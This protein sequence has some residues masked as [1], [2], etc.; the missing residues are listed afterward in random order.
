MRKDQLMTK[1]YRKK[2]IEIMVEA[3]RARAIID[4]I[5]KAGAKGYTIVPE[6]SGKGHRG[7]RDDAHLTDVFRNVMIIVVAAEDIAHRII[8]HALPLLENYAGIVV[9][10]DAEVIRDEHF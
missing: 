2:K 8:E 6:V 1:L 9:V 3:A 5:E 10:S 7:L 4:L